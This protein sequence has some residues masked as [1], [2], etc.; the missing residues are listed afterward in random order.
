MTADPRQSL[1]MASGLC[2]LEDAVACANLACDQCRAQ[3]GTGPVDL[4]LVSFSGTHVEHAPEILGVVRRSLDPHC[5]LGV[6]AESV[7]GGESELERV[8][9]ISILA[10]R[11]PGVEC[12]PITSDRFPSTDLDPDELDSQLGAAI[13][14]GP[15]LRGVILLA[16]PYSTPLVRL[17]PALNRA[18]DTAGARGAPIIGGLA[19]AARRAGDNILAIDDRIT[20]RGV[21]GV[22]LKG[23]LRIDTVV[24]Q[25]CR[26]FGP[27]M[28]IT[29]ARGN[30]IF[31]IGGR[32]ALQVAQQHIAELPE[33]E[34]SL[35]SGGLFIGRAV[36]E[37]KERFGRDDFLNRGVV[38]VDQTSGAIAVADLVRTGQTIRFHLRDAK[39]AS[40]DLALLLDG[41]KLHERPAG[42]FII[43]CNGRGTRLFERPHHDAFA[44]ARAFDP[45]RGGEELAKGGMMIDPSGVIA[46]ALRPK[47]AASPPN[48]PGTQEPVPAAP[49]PAETGRRVRTA[50][51]PLAGFFASGE[52]GPVGGAS[53]MHNHTA[54]IALFRPA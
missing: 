12:V 40:D 33:A 20:D 2:G 18:R 47:S 14:A 28:L 7:L 52:I 34:R 31:E 46:L 45:A 37:Y 16:D 3:L 42:A 1:L 25:G 50:S 43:T 30:I 11:L 13:G 36:N 26:G 51:I 44:V 53:Y 35:L 41:Q 6:S 17:L 19:S 4:A 54:C 23:R 32:P 10:G 9:A 8:S 27:P 38:N 15:D 24:S 29:K 22:A 48:E 5:L 21:V 39:S 49:D